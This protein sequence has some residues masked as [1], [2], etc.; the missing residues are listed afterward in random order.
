MSRDEM[1]CDKVLWNTFQIERV[2][3]TSSR[4]YGDIFKTS[5]PIA[6]TDSGIVLAATLK[7]TPSTGLPN[8]RIKNVDQIKY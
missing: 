8:L 4:S 5:F 7:P 1:S 2:F 6:A 3:D